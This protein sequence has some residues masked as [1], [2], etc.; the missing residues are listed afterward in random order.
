MDMT[1]ANVIATAD[2]IT[3]L[4]KPENG[5]VLNSSSI[6][7]GRTAKS[8]LPRPALCC[9]P[10]GSSTLSLILVSLYIFS[11]FNISKKSLEFLPTIL[12][13]FVGDS[14][15]VGWEHLDLEA[16]TCIQQLIKIRDDDLSLNSSKTLL[17]K[18]D[19][20][21]LRKFKNN[22]GESF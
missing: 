6:R 14:G 1:I 15:H 18:W 7:L 12:L 2:T 4:I 3:D 19:S 21:M 8:F 22:C 16:H 20:L 9:R 11:E 10:Y 17:S 13:L 5:F